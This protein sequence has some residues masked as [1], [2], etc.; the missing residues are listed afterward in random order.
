MKLEDYGI[1]PESGYHSK[2]LT[3]TEN[4]FLGLLWV[5]HLGEDNKISA[6]ELAIRF[7]YAGSGHEIPEKRMASLL[8]G[9]RNFSGP[10]LDGL[11]RDVRKMQ[12]HIMMEHDN[13]PILSKAGIGG[14]YWIASS[15]EEGSK[16]Y[17]SFRQ[18]GLTGLVKAS[19]GKKAVMVDIL[20]QLSFGFDDLVDKTGLIGKYEKDN[21]PMAITIVDTFLEKMMKNPEQYADDL[22]RIGEKF[23]SILLP[24]SQVTEMQKKAKEMQDIL[25]RLTMVA[26]LFPVT[27]FLG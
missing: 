21:T 9:Y 27:F 16:F 14:G 17:D 20:S 24:K 15:K 10:V 19:R 23:G 13:I 5:D 6:D 3:G 25:T 12:N 8:E 18:R 7:F 11:K 1:N 26:V 2:I 4:N 22:R